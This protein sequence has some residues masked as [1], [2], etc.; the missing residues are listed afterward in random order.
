[1]TSTELIR[2]LLKEFR[3]SQT[4]LGRQ[5]G[6]KSPGTISNRLRRDNM[7]V[8]TL[9]DTLEVFEYEL[10]ARPVGSTDTAKD[11]ILSK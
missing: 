3:A 10:V 7:T 11:I 6:H 4:A 1:M 2:M 8:S 5:L 9:L